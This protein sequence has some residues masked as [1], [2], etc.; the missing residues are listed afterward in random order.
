MALQYIIHWKN[1]Q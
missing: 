1:R